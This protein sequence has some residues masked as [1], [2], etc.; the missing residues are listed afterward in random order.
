MIS[1]QHRTIFVHIPKCAGQSVE[2]TFLLDMSDDLNWESHR[3]LLGCFQR[4]PSWPA[5]F[6]DRIAHLTASEYTKLR[7]VSPKLWNDFFKFTIIRDPVDRVVS[8]WRYLPPMHDLEGFV[9]NYLPQAMAEDHYFFRSQCRYVCSDDTGEPI[10]DVVLPFSELKERWH[11]V[12]ERCGLK[13]DLIHRNRSH[14][15]A[16]PLVSDAVVERIK[17]LYCDDYALLEKLAA[18]PPLS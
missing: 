3:H 8:M 16:A 13:T 14:K 7:F 4:P 5:E 15:M 18:S 9:M 1:L 2:E 10:V 11:V 17:S 12:Q 6:P